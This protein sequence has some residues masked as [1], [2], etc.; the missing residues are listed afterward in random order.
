MTRR[1]FRFARRAAILSA[2]TGVH[3]ALGSLSDF[4]NIEPFRVSMLWLPAGLAVAAIM[5]LGRPAVL[6]VFVAALI[7][8]LQ[9][10]TSLGVVFAIAMGIALQ[11]AVVTWLI[12][13]WCRVGVWAAKGADPRFRWSLNQSEFPVF[14]YYGLIALGAMTAPTIGALILCGSGTASWAA[15]PTNW[16]AWWIGDTLGIAVLTPIV[17]AAWSRWKNATETFLW[18]QPLAMLLM[19]LGVIIFWMHMAVEFG[20]PLRMVGGEM[21]STIGF[22]YRRLAAEEGGADGGAGV[23]HAPNE[24]KL[25]VIGQAGAG[26]VVEEKQGLGA[27]GEDRKSTRLNSSHT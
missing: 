11:G 22:P 6:A 18:Q 20:L 25:G 21:E 16:I 1:D 9:Y 24:G 26:D 4:G 3:L 5:Q 14:R 13:R 12:G 19:P 17:F 7:N 23:G 8:N 10:D 2:L 27:R 15:F